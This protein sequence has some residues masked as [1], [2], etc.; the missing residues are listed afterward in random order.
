MLNEDKNRER[1]NLASE[2]DKCHN[3]NTKMYQAVKCINRKPLQNLMVHDK[4]GR[5]LTEP[6]AVY[7][8]IRDHF[9]A[10]FNYPKESKLEPFIGNSR[11]LDK[12]IT[13]D[14]VAKSI[15]KL[16]NNI[17]PGYD[18]IPPELLKYAPPES[19]D[20]VAESLNNIFAKHEYI[21]VGI[22][23]R[24][25]LQK[26]GKPKGPTRSLRRMSLLIMIRK[27]ISSIVLSRI[28]PTM[29]KYLSHS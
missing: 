7:H 28:Q 9:K 13:K 15:Y 10:H 17:T 20:L 18:Q 4:A 21:N 14:E 5:N 19:Y 26:P 8:I 22:G 23:L 3:D 27:I 24:T 11:P 12:P 25:A 2:I 1:D 6:N 29:E 16:Q